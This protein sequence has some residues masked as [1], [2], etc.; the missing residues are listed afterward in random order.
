M[1]II[2]DSEK[3][4][5][6]LDTATSSYIFEIYEQ[7]YLVHLYYGAKIPDYNLSEFRYTGGFASFSPNNASVKNWAFPK[8]GPVRSRS[9]PW[10]SCR[11]L[12]KVWA[13]RII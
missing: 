4:I 9:R 6:K 13:W 11:S 3:K 5:F 10:K 7:N 12:E 8:N 2:F 1:P